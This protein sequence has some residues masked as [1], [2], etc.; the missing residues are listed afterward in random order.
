MITTRR[1]YL[2]ATGLGGGGVLAGAAAATLSG[3][4]ATAQTAD[5]SHQAVAGV[6]SGALNSTVLGEQRRYT[7]W[8]SNG[9]ETSQDSYPVLFLLD[10]PRHFSY[11]TG[12]VDYLSR[13]GEAIAPAIVVD[14][15]QQHRGRDMTPT[16]DKQNPGDSGGADRFLSFLAKELVPHIASRYRTKAPL[17]LWGYSL[18]GLFAFHALLTEPGLFDGYILASPAIWWDDSLLVRRAAAFFKQHTSLDRKMFFGVG[19][20]ER[21][22]VQDYFG[23]ISR[24]LHEN[25]PKGFAAT[26]RKFEGEEHNTI[27]IPTT[28]Y[29]LKAVFPK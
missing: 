7:V 2:R 26:L 16:P 25:T 3:L 12:M 24:I 29:G 6:Q 1:D 11:V 21:Q 9:Y 17:V 4:T 22:A 14:I 8:L 10:G 5:R 13:Y 23:E 19:A 15:E 18:S 27:C 28:Y 20:K